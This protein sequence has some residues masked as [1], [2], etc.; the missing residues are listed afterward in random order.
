MK[1]TDVT[2]VKHM[3]DILKHKD[4]KLDSFMTNAT[5]GFIKQGVHWRTKLVVFTI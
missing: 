2:E 4:E 5:P 1:N 3:S